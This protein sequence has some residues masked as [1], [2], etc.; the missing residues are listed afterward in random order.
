MKSYMY[1]GMVIIN[2]EGIDGGEVTN[3]PKLSGN[4][5]YSIGEYGENG[6]PAPQESG[7]SDKDAMETGLTCR[8]PL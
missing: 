2:D 1:D 7:W 5:D 8:K 6:K 3:K 4:K